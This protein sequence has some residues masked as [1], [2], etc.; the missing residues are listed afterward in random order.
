MDVFG[1]E[2]VNRTMLRFGDRMRDFRRP[3]Q[4]IVKDHL[5]PAARKQF[6]TQGGFGSGGWPAISP[7]RRAEKLRQG[8]DPRILHATH[9]LRDSFQGGSDAVLEVGRDELRWGSRV[10]YGKYHRKTR[11]PVQLPR[12]VRVEIVKDLQRSIV[13]ADRS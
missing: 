7:E 2:I 8:L 6:A 4:N 13:E 5:R 11:P 9:A 12:A 10:S 3:F 1:D